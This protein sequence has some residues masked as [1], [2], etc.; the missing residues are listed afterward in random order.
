MNGTI[1]LQ[2]QLGIGVLQVDIDQMQ[3][4]IIVQYL[5]IIH[6]PIMHMALLWEIVALQITLLQ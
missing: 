1:L 3:R 5:V 4:A 6:L 2:I